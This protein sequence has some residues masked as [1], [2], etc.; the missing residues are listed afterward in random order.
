MVEWLPFGDQI[1]EISPS[2][3]R[4]VYAR[5]TLAACATHKDFKV[6]ELRRHDRDGAIADIIVVD[7]LNDR[8]PSRNSI[9]IKNRERLALIFSGDDTQVPQVRAL[10]K[11]FPATPHQ[12]LVLP[13]E[14]VS[15]C[16]YLAPWSAVERTWTPQHHLQRVLWWLAETAKGTLH[17]DDQPVEQIYFDSTVEIIVPPNFNERCKDETATL[18]LIKVP[19]DKKQT[20]YLSQFV[21]KE[22]AARIN[23]PNVVPLPILLPP[24]VHGRTEPFPCNLGELETQLASRGIRF[25]EILRDKVRQVVPAQGVSRDTAG[26]VALIL[27]VPITRSVN[28]PIERT[29]LRGFVVTQDLSSLG[30]AIGALHNYNGRFFSIQEFGGSPTCEEARWRGMLV[31]PI[32]LSIRLTREFARK[33]SDVVVETADFSGILAGVG[34][35]GSALAELWSR[36]AWGAWTLIDMDHL[37]AHNVARHICNDRYVGFYKAHAVKAMVSA[38]YYPQYAVVEAI[39]HSVMDWKNEKVREAFA[40]ADFVV[41]ATTALEVPREFSQREDVPR[42]ASVFLTPSGLGSVLLMEDAERRI[43]LDSLEAQ[44]YRAI[45]NNEWGA[46]HLAG[47]RDDLRIGTGCRERSVVISVESVQMHAGILAR[48]VR[49]G[50][51]RSAPQIRVWSCDSETGAVAAAAPAALPTLSEQCGSWRVVW[52]EGVRSRLRELREQN[53]PN[54]TGGVIVG[55]IDQKLRSIFIVDVLPAP[56]DSLGDRTGFTRGVAGL[57]ERL[58]DIGKRTAGVVQY[59]GEWHSHPRWASAR[60]SSADFK[61]IRYL[62][63]ILVLDGQPAVMMIVGED[64]ICIAVQEECAAGPQ[65]QSST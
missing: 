17:R 10:R 42:A 50:R 48:Q 26:N 37:K 65:I 20:V 32:A 15:L 64:D 39:A 43:R 40:K 31:T 4:T 12:N 30:E 44:Y 47:R 53:L 18:V 51:D 33:A 3:L 13:G 6:V 62:A 11:D 60:P 22:E 59:V 21:T 7:C 58:E 27:S 19:E 38:N 14:P 1:A 23:S 9:G 24:V 29:D 16:L 36:E 5:R 8:V 2:A 52:D 57:R 46:T 41:D 54:E 55:Y 56:R 35:L 25:V 45:I 34:A 49:C 61:L 63:E 28:G